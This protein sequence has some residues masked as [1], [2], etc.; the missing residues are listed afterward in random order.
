VRFI[1]TGRLVAYKAADLLL[2]A[3]AQVVQ[4]VDARL[5]VVGDGPFRPSLEQRARHLGVAQ[6]VTFH[7]WRSLRESSDLLRAA[8]VYVLPTLREPGGISVLEAMASGLPCVVA[9]WG[10][11]AEFVGDTGLRVG[12]TSAS[13]FVPRLAEAMSALAGAPERRVALGAAA[14]ARVEARYD[15]DTLTDRLLGLYGQ[16]AAGGV[17]SATPAPVFAPRPASTAAPH[18]AEPGGGAR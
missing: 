12:V 9:D 7:G 14:R 15:W 5:D 3:F 8:D 4:Q 13:R 11:P 2:E 6:R 16:A 10:G 17:G 18:G 1:Y